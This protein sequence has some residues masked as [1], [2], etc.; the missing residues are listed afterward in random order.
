MV[1]SR[2]DDVVARLVFGDALVYPVS[3]TEGNVMRKRDLG[4]VQVERGT[5]IGIQVT[6]RRDRKRPKHVLAGCRKVIG[7]WRCGCGCG[8]VRHAFTLETGCAISA[9]GVTGG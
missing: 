3:T 1:S 4:D 5:G 7:F 9:S 2:D 8:L 6:V